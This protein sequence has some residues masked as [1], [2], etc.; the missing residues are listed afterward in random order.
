[1]VAAGKVAVCSKSRLT[2]SGSQISEV[3][4]EGRRGG[5]E[6]NVYQVP[7][8]LHVGSTKEVV[9]GINAF[10]GDLFGEL[11]YEPVEFEKD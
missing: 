5:E 4:I 2:P 1:M 7:E 6:M 8:L 11:D 9:L 3:Q 10:G